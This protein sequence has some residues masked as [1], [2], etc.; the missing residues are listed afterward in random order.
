MAELPEDEQFPIH[1]ETF[2][3]ECGDEGCTCWK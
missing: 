2:C 1:V 3:P